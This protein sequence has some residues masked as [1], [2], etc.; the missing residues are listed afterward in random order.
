M[1]DEIDGRVKKHQ[2]EIWKSLRSYADPGVVKKGRED[3]I[4]HLGGIIQ[5]AIFLNLD[6]KKYE[7]DVSLSFGAS[8]IGF[9]SNFEPGRMVEVVYSRGEGAVGLVVSPPFYKELDT[10]TGATERRFLR[11]AEVSSGT[12]TRPAQG[13]VQKAISKVYTLETR[14]VKDD[15]KN[16]A[17]DIPPQNRT[18]SKSRSSKESLGS[19]TRPAPILGLRG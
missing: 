8:K 15:G 11:K 16:R 6:I 10:A 19:G 4:A 3:A 18:S 13:G 12:V 17:H 1:Q 2:T 14:R 5:S 7:A 9:G